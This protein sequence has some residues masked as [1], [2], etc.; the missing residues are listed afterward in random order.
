[1]IKKHT[2]IWKYTDT[3]KN[4]GDKRI[5][6]SPFEMLVK[7]CGLKQIYFT[8]QGWVNFK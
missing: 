2:H 1:M 7:G 6:E 8:G 3:N 5:C 4:N